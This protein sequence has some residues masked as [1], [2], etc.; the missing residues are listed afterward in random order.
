MSGNESK[1]NW[2]VVVIGGGMAGM[3]AAL[4]LGRARQRVLLVDG[5]APRNRKVSHSHGLLTRDGASPAELIAAGRKDLAHYPHIVIRQELVQTL[6]GASDDWQIEMASGEQIGARRLILATGVRD[7][8]LPIPGLQERLG[9]EVQFCPYCHG[10]EWRDQPLAVLALDENGL[11]HARLLM[12]WTQDL[13][14][15]THGLAI[16]QAS[17]AGLRG[18]GIKLEQDPLLE[19]APGPE[20]L[21]VRTAAGSQVYT[22]LFTAPQ[23]MHQSPLVAELG[24]DLT[25]QGFIAV[26]AMQQTSVPGIFAA[27]DCARMMHSLSFAVSDGVMAG[28][29]CHRSLLF[30]GQQNP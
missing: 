15:Y 5:G 4:Q 21:E 6:S 10:Y 23:K 29:A 27:G 19:V 26:D 8:L 30:P 12:Q 3:A 18:A 14:V 11:H 16:N 9:Q 20:G 28:I 25:P 24:C 2:D 7:E 1:A 22:G 17:L 13:T